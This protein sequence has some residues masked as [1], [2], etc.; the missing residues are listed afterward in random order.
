M[1]IGGKKQSSN[2]FNDEDSRKHKG[3]IMN[4]L[5]SEGGEKTLL[6]TAPG[7]PSCQNQDLI[8]LP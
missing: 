7:L 3:H 6:S 2:T 8:L 5:Y 4:D 1:N